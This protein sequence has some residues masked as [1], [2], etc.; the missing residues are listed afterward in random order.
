MRDLKERTCCFSG[1][2]IVPD[3]QKP[4]LEKKLDDVIAGLRKEG[5]DR[6]VCGGAIGFDTLAAQAV[7]RAKK[8]D[9]SLILILALPC[10]DQAEKWSSK[11]RMI[12]LNTV[13]AADVVH[14]VSPEYSSG[15]MHKRNRFMVGMSSH[16]V[17]YLTKNLGG[18]YYTVQCAVKAG[19][20]MHPLA[21]NEDRT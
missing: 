3:E 13:R 17:Y 8:T 15:C 2:R 18:T 10:P 16:C 14:I 6:F 20:K 7:L 11:D 19:L 4:V 5:V 9:P 21:E 1:H 12:Y